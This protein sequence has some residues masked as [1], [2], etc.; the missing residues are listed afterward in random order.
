MGRVV[1]IVLDDGAC[2]YL[3]KCSVERNF[4]YWPIMN[5]HYNEVLFSRHRVKQGLWINMVS[6]NISASGPRGPKIGFVKHVMGERNADGYVALQVRRQL[7]NKSILGLPASM[8]QSNLSSLRRRNPYYTRKI[9]IVLKELRTNVE[10]VAKIE[11]PKDISSKPP[12]E[13]VE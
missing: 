5:Y 9:K 12:N 7:K 3:T 2:E 11:I 8:F 4:Y 13:N 10:V 6:D 1:T